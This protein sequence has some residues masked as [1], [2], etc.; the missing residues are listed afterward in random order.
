MNFGCFRR[1]LV[2]EEKL[3]GCNKELILSVWVISWNKQN[4]KCYYFVFWLTNAQ[5]FH[6]LSQSYM[7][8]HYRVILRVFVIST[9]TV[10]LLL[11][12]TMTNKCTIISQ[13]ITLLHVSTLS[14]HPQAACN[15]NLA[16]LHKYFKCSCWQYNLQLRRFTQVLWKF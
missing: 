16:E 15:Q 7:F 4:V 6:K 8:R 10:R 11:F 13:I 12:C 1:K 3:L 2:G 14:C 9:C 5:L